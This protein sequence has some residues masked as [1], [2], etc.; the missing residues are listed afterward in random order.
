LKERSHKSSVSESSDPSSIPA[1]DPEVQRPGFEA[2]DSSSILASRR[3]SDSSSGL[4][5]FRY[6]FGFGGR[7]SGPDF[8]TAGARV[9]RFQLAS[10]IYACGR[11]NAPTIAD[12]ATQSGWPKYRRIF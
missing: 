12:I 8:R 3:F 5:F 4:G 10:S 7:S 2:G 1:A 9:P 6:F 11:S